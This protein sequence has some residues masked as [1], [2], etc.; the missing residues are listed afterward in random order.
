MKEDTSATKKM[1]ID[2]SPSPVKILVVDDDCIIREMLKNILEQEEYVVD[3]SESSGDALEKLIDY[4]YSLLLLDANLP[5]ISGFELLKYCKKHHPLMEIIMITG[6]PELDDAISTVKDGA[7]DYIAK[8]FSVDKLTSRIKA[9]LTHHREELIKNFSTH[10]NSLLTKSGNPQ[11][12]LPGYK[13]LRTLGAGT[14]GVVFLVEK[15]KKRYAL[16][17]LRKEGG[18]SSDSLRVKRFLRE[19]KILSQ[20]EHPNVVKVYDSDIP[21][22]SSSPYILME[23]VKGKPLTD[24]IKKSTCPLTLEQKLWFFCALF[25]SEADTRNNRPPCAV[26]GNPA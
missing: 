6:N 13:I 16:K 1:D 18:E 11:T 19:A 15:R 14:M 2:E 21:K 9:A 20:I 24:F 8:P 26:K 10:G 5:G 23:Y 12:P 17:V 3:L 7:F 4:N 22:D 25:R